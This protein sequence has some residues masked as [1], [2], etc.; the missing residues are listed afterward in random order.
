VLSHP[1]AC[2]LTHNVCKLHIGLLIKKVA[3]GLRTVEPLLQSECV[4]LQPR[5]LQ[6]SL[7][8][9]TALLIF[10][11]APVCSLLLRSCQN[12]GNCVVP[13]TC[14]CSGTGHTGGVCENPGAFRYHILAHL[15]VKQHHLGRD[16]S[17]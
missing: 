8:A 2:R 17:M 10:V 11:L 6:A 4:S 12:A 3:S 9:P 15:T 1:V 14:D 16:S 5:H 7:L 13:D